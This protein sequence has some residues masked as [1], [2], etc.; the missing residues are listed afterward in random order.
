M[1]TQALKRDADVG[2]Q[3]LSPTPEIELTP[4]QFYVII[5]GLVSVKTTRRAQGVPLLSGGVAPRP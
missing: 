5:P 3:K 1:M 2:I 4:G